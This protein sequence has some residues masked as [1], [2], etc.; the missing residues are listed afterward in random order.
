MREGGCGAVAARVFG[1]VGGSVEQPIG[2]N[3]IS[4]DMK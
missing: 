3:R 4:F 1:D 2:R